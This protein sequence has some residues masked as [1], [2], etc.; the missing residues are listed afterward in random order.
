M[1]YHDSGKCAY[2]DTF[3]VLEQL[4]LDSCG[5]RGSLGKFRVFQGGDYNLHPFVLR[6]LGAVTHKDSNQRGLD[7]C[8]NGSGQTQDCGG[9][10]LAELHGPRG[11][12][13]RIALGGLHYIMVEEVS[14]C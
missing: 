9:S 1:L 3:G 8:V 14:G 7:V 2:V 6:P 5:S 4:K 10:N 11:V 13:L 12:D